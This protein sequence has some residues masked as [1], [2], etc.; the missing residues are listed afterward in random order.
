MK[1]DVGVGVVILIVIVSLSAAIGIGMFTGQSENLKDL[2]NNTADNT[3]TKVSNA[4]CQRECITDHPSKG[5]GYYTCL[6]N[7]GC[8]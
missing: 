4:S 5:S 2:T 8:T 3:S 1:G 7:N 6:D